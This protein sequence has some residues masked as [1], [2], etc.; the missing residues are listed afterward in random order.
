MIHGHYT[1]VKVISLHILHPIMKIGIFKPSCVS[2]VVPTSVSI[3]QL[4]TH[5]NNRL[6]N[7]IYKTVKK[8]SYSIAKFDLLLKPSCT[9][10]RPKAI[11][12]KNS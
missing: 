6:E 9:K 11:F 5:S 10:V 12:G 2:A 3:T 8:D 1:I 4:L 7:Y